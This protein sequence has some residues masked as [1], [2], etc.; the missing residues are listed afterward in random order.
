MSCIMND[1]NLIPMAIQHTFAVQNWLSSRSPDAARFQG[2]GVRASST[3]YPAPLLN[4]ALGAKYPNSTAD[5][6]IDALDAS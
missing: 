3:G 4:L 6:E 5:D 1:S 2:L